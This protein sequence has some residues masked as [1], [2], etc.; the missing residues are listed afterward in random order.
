MIVTPPANVP[1]HTCTV[2]PL[3]AAATAAASVAAVDPGQ[4]SVTGTVT[5]AAGCALAV[6]P[7]AAAIATTTPPTTAPARHR[8]TRPPLARTCA[9]I[10]APPDRAPAVTDRSRTGRAKN[11][12]G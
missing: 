8:R 6:A 10:P 1:A 2:P 12:A 11:G 7:D 3:G 4:P 9:P 5:G